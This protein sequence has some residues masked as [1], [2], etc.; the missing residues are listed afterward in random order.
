MEHDI[1]KAILKTDWR[2]TTNVI[3]FHSDT[4]TT[5]SANMGIYEK[6]QASSFKRRHPHTMSLALVCACALFL[7]PI[8]N[9][10]AARHCMRQDALGKCRRI[11]WTLFRLPRA[12]ITT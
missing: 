11:A 3:T 9:S 5:G 8:P 4:G 6:Q 10:A 7:T 12:P 1:K 2:F